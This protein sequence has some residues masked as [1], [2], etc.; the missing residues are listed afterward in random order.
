MD[1]LVLGTSL[2]YA[3][4]NTN[5]LWDEY[6]IAAYDLCS[7]EQPF[8]ISYYYLLEAL[9]TQK[10][11]VIL[12]DAKPAIYGQ[13]YSKEGRALLST[14]G[15]LSPLTR[16]KAIHACVG[17]ERMA[18]V[19]LAFPKLHRNYAN[20]MAEDFV[21]PPATGGVAIP[22]RATS[23]RTRRSGTKGPRWYGW[24]PNGRSTRARKST[25]ARSSGSRSSGAFRCL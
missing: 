11:A 4:I 9:R 6:G 19:A 18:D 20:L 5:V 16:L 1:V 12:L 7:A 3:G 17:G 25:P 23:R 2:A 13:D 14:S 21:F 22:G 15:I 24:R 8:W 10:P